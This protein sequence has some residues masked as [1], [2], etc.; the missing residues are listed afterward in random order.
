MAAS[1]IVRQDLIDLIARATEVD[2]TWCGFVAAYMRCSPMHDYKAFTKLRLPAG[3]TFTMNVVC[4]THQLRLGDVV[5]SSKLDEAFTSATVINV[6]E[7][8]VVLFRPYVHTGDFSHTGGV[9]P[10][11]GFEQYKLS[12]NHGQ[13]VY[14]Y[15]RKELA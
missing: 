14:L 8:E 6:T 1:F 5:N 10:Y 4:E 15:S 7:D 2:S 11:V 12:R 13:P 3:Y 9:T